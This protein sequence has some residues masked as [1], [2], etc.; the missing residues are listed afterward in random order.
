MESFDGSEHILERFWERAN[1]GGRDYKTMSLFKAGEKFM[2]TGPPRLSPTIIACCY[3]ISENL[4]GRK[5]KRKS[6]KSGTDVSPPASPQP[7]SSTASVGGPSTEKR[8]RS[9]PVTVESDEDRPRKRTRENV[10]EPPVQASPPKQRIPLPGQNKRRIQKNPTEPQ[11]PLP[12]PSRPTPRKTRPSSFDEIIPASD[13]EIEELND[14][15]EP[16]T[17]SFLDMD[18]DIQIISG[19]TAGGG[20]SA[21]RSN[22]VATQDVQMT[23]GDSSSQDEPHP[24]FD[25]PD[26]DQQSIIPSHRERA[27]NPRVKMVDNPA[28][29][30]MDGAIPVKARLLGRSSAPSPSASGTPRKNPNHSGAHASGSKPG[31]GRSSSGFMKKNKSSLLTFEKGALKTV[32]GRYNNLLEE[33]RKETQAPSYTIEDVASENGP[34]LEDEISDDDD[35]SGLMYPIAPVPPTA[36][37]LLKLA[38][39]NEQ[40]AVILPDFEDETPTEP[41]KS[42]IQQR[43][44]LNMTYLSCLIFYNSLALAKDKLFPAGATP[45]SVFN[46]IGTAWKRSTIFGPLFVKFSSKYLLL[47]TMHTAVLPLIHNLNPPSLYPLDCE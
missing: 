43:Y 4:P 27:A 42:T 39:L 10:P 34:A 20:P 18:D 5:P 14:A 37:E 11:V 47:L 24:L 2:P 22:N 26:E 19:G 1:V 17:Q 12:K 31:P 38:G 32:K 23:Q 3:F 8:R 44:V 41:E 16:P 36:E 35:I 46:S 28:V 9:A 45:A 21:S 30:D 6:L 7:N 13:E 25:S 29:N 33:K 15:R 40:S